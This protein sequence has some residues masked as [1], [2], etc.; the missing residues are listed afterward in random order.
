MRLRQLIALFAVLT[1]AGPSAALA[2][3]TTTT[4]ES[5]GKL[6]L[7]LD[8]S[9]SMKESASGGGTKIDAAK[10]A[11]KQVVSELP[12]GAQVGMRVFGAKVFSAKDKG[13]CADTQNVVPVGTLD[14]A[15]LL[16]QID[17]YKPYGETPI[18]NALKGAA[19][20]LGT[21]G[22]RT[23][24][25]LSDGEPT[26]SPDPC[27]VAKALRKSGV[28]LKINVVGLS[29][30]GKARSALQCIADG[31]GG[32]YYD[33]NSPQE[34]A[35]SLVTVSVR[36][37]R[38]FSIKGKPISGGRTA[39]SATPVK[40]GQ[41][42]DTSKGE[43]T[44]NYYLLKKP[45]GGSVAVAVTSRPPTDGEFTQS[46][47]VELL[48]PD[49]TSC[50]RT[51][52]RRVNILQTR[53]ILSSGAYFAPNDMRMR[54]STPCLKA[55]EFVARVAYDGTSTKVPYE[56]VVQTFPKIANLAN[57]PPAVERAEFASYVTP[58]RG[59]GEGEP[60]VGG[61]SFN[62]SPSIKDGLYTD[63]L[64]AGE[65]LIY[66]VPVGWGQVPRMTITVESDANASRVLGILG[67]SLNLGAFN[68][69]RQPLQQSFNVDTGA[70]GSGRYMGGEPEVL[71]AA[72]IPVRARNIEPIE[73]T[74]N[75]NA[76]AGDY[77][78]SIEMGAPGD[79]ERNFAAPLTIAVE[80]EGKE[81]G[82][83]KYARAFTKA[84]DKA[85]TRDKADSDGG[86]STVLL[87]GVG[88]VAV[89]TLGSGALILRRRRGKQATRA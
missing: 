78:F 29:V 12:D 34:L 55:T 6:M 75:E 1:L 32:T 53:S 68:P 80:V 69:L 88:T 64:R 23:I 77:Y 70:R 89:L 39:T 18:G 52:D 85:K 43:G 86:V 72:F 15:A 13:A 5:E 19:K 83:P 50:T 76:M 36:A 20:D 47:T 82:A 11:L 59:Q 74:V 31:G 63:T 27:T 60:I 87:V 84:G 30:S 58:V 56:L 81:S 28:D 41:Y 57:L 35:A 66:R 49:G 3:D 71:T 26:C 62:D 16:A 51:H 9:G 45:Q 14:R 42:T 25:L 33:V 21:T 17:S 46:L 2:A 4:D 48:T 8:S 37:L 38:E 40:T 79:G 44:D 7:V 22:K 54:N 67:I 61:A 24:V 10:K 73:T 65:Q